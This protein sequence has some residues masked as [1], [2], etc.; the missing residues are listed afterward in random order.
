MHFAKLL[1]RELE[2]AKKLQKLLKQFEKA[3]KHAMHG[4]TAA[5]AQLKQYAD[6]KTTV[7]KVAASV[8]AGI[9]E[10]HRQKVFNDLLATGILDEVRVSA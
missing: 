1:F 2:K 4:C 10:D 5:Q 3:L 8:D 9:T 7:D 6:W